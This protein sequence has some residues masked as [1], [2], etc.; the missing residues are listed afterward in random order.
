MAMRPTGQATHEDAP[1][2]D[3]DPGGQLEHAEAPARGENRPA[4]H[5]GQL[6]AA[7]DGPYF[8]AAQLEHELAPDT[9]A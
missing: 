7:V 2:A 6:D 8:P 9:A 1:L 3:V 4:S 5:A